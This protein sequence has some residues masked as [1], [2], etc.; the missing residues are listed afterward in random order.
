MSKQLRAVIAALCI[1]SLAGC[2]GGGDHSAGAI[3]TIGG[4]VSGL[5]GKVVLQNNAGDTLPVTTNGTFTF[6]TA[7]GKGATYAVTVLTQPAGPD[8]AVANGS[9]AAT[10]NV[11]NVSV[12]CTTDPNTTFVPIAAKAVSGSTDP[13]ATGL[14]VIS[15]KSPGN[16]PI[17]VAKEQIDLLDEQAQYSVNPQ[18]TVSTTNPYAL[19][20]TTQNSASGDHVWSLNLLGSS[21]L[22]PRQISNLTLPYHE[23]TRSN[24]AVAHACISR[25][26]P[27]KLD[28]PGSAFLILALPADNPPYCPANRSGLKWLLVHLSDSPTTDPVTLPPLAGSI[29]PL[30]RPD[31]TLAGL[32]AVDASNNLNLYPDET[33]ANPRLLQANVASFSPV[34]EAT[35]GPDSSISSNPTYSFLL[36]N[37]SPIFDGPLSVY[38]VDYSGSISADLYDLPGRPDATIVHAGTVYFSRVTGIS[39][40]GSALVGRIPGDGGAAQTLATLSNVP[41]SRLPTLAGVS[42]SRLVLYSNDSVTTVPMDTPGTFTT[43]ASYDDSLPVVLLAGGDIFVTTGK[44]IQGPVLNIQ[45]VTQIFDSTG[46]VLQADMPSSAFISSGGA[47]VIQLRNMTATGNADGGSLYVFDLSNPASP[48][49]VALKASNGTP[50]TVPD[51]DH[52]LFFSPLTPTISVTD[53]AAEPGGPTTGALLYNSAKGVVVP[54]SMPNSNFYFPTAFLNYGN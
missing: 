53:G 41:T 2:G 18:G 32:A 22:V 12:T 54:I 26:I 40:S 16:P 42:G 21:T 14:F 23:V 46:N 10:D 52:S 43:I 9:G 27:K 37:R 24:G 36:I 17:Q 31:G 7:L 47:P 15:S 8:C 38:R 44:V 6:P 11:T 48:N 3:V 49:P 34:Q 4:T 30:Y 33:F 25:V 1:A 28:D 45:Y 50:F 35:A 20:Y 5:V 39:G 13:G 19:T 29:L 51:A